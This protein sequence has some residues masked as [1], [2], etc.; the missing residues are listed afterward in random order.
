MML[1]SSLL[2]LAGAFAATPALADSDA[3]PQAAAAADAPASSD[4]LVTARR[5]SEKLID[6]PAAIT[7]LSAEALKS[8]GITNPTDL[9]HAIPSLQE[10]A[11][12][13]GNA[14]PHFLIRGQRQQLEFIQSDQSVGVYIDEVVVP[15]QQGLNAGMFD[16]ANVQV[17][18]GPQGTLFGKN[19]TAGAILFSSQM[20]KRDFGGY[21]TATIGNYDA[22]KVEGAI[23][24]P[25]TEDLQL[26]A[27]GL[28]NRRD[29]YVHNLTDN[30]NYSDVHSDGWR[31]SAH[32]APS[33]IPLE[34]WLT[35]SG[36]TENEI[37]TEPTQP[38]RFL[39]AYGGSFGAPVGVFGLFGALSGGANVNGNAMLSNA[40][41]AQSQSYGPYQTSGIDQFQLPNGNNVA[42]TN[43]SGTNKTEYHLG[44]AI[45]LR[46]IFGYRFLRSYTG[47]NMSGVA[48]VL[49]VPGTTAIN[50]GNPG[51][52]LANPATNVV[53]GPQS[54]IYCVLATPIQGMNFTRQRQISDEVDLLGKALDN[55]LDY[56]LGG[57]YFRE[58]GDV[59]TGSLNAITTANRWGIAQNSPANESKAVFGQATYH[60]SPT[61]AVTGGL[62][63]TWDTRETNAKGIRLIPNY[64]P[65][66]G[67]I[68]PADGVNA[69]CAIKDS[70]GN[71]LADNACLVS[72]TASFQKLTYTASVDWHP[73]RDTLLYAAT[74]TG[75]RSG[76]FNQSTLVGASVTQTFQ[77]E[78]VTD[79]EIGYK[80]NWRFDNGMA[81]GF[82]IDYY[83][84]YYNNIQRALQ[85]STALGSKTVTR[86]AAKAVIDGVEIEARFEP[87]HWLELTGYFSRINAKFKSF[88]VAPDPSLAAASIGDFTLGKFSGVPD[89]SGGAT[90]TLHTDVPGDKG[91]VAASLDYYGQTGT[92][93]Q[94]NNVVGNT[95]NPI[96]SDYIPGYWLLGANVSWTQVMGKPID[97]NFN[98]RNLNKKVYYT[99]GVDGATSALGTSSMFVGEPRMYTFSLSYHF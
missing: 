5:K 86:N 16:M 28:I 82:N 1:S 56:I 2:G 18:K 30:R 57:Y 65:W 31:I 36:A 45:T 91:R 25:L 58:H 63:Q 70:S 15:R 26:R 94:D 21:F 84:D 96:T 60:V 44:D 76:G 41:V 24:V 6:V 64:W 49:L 74:R 32:Y 34:N 47:T 66:A 67:G 50:A 14:V 23:N 83:R 93:M 46:N 88:I 78:T 51:T 3:A 40:I 38:S 53:C 95:A 62:R 81:A 54:G 59:V 13:F 12:G 29:G 79:Y 22:R 7:V 9:I 11:S 52:I 43:F 37:G 77:P 97:L 87:T 72:A 99:G 8:K 90:I 4:I 92:F 89:A 68:I 42:I 27:A 55:K 69:H 17:L 73:T 71:F 10:S 80:G 39:G 35:F 19:Q 48:G 20:P 98:V 75:Y 85:A 33:S 61:V